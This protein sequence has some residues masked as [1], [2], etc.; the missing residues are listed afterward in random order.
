MTHT[1]QMWIVVNPQGEPI[2]SK[3]SV[4][5]PKLFSVDEKLGYTVQPVIVTIELP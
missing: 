3:L 4:I 5:Q 2:F 1:K